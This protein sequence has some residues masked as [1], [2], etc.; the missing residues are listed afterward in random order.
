MP[1][2]YLCVSCTPVGTSRGVPRAFGLVASS[3]LSDAINLRETSC[4]ICTYVNHK[5]RDLGSFL[6]RGMQRAVLIGGVS[7]SGNFPLQRRRGERGESRGPPTT[8][9][10]TAHSPRHQPIA[11]HTAHAPLRAFSLR[12]FA[13]Y[14]RPSVY[15]SEPW[16]APSRPQLL[17]RP[18]PLCR[19]LKTSASQHQRPWSL[20]DSVKRQNSRKLSQR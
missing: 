16:R 7:N 10:L 19:H 18:L 1:S 15:T 13:L 11:L 9:S 3:V 2:L 20:H 6:Q 5:S 12:G 14:T 17:S 8:S 4:G